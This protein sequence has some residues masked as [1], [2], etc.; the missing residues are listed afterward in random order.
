MGTAREDHGFAA[1]G[2]KLYVFGGDNDGESTTSVD[3][4]DPISNTWVKVSDL[5]CARE[6]FVTVAL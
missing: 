5:H 2:G 4:Y 1:I 6:E 3:A